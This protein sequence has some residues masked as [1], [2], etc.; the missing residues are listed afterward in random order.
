[1]K[2]YCRI[3]I[4]TI[5]QDSEMYSISRVRHVDVQCLTF[6]NVLTTKIE[7]FEIR[8][9]CSVIQRVPKFLFFIKFVFR[10]KLLRTNINYCTTVQ[11]ITS[12]LLLLYCCITALLYY[13]IYVLQSRKFKRDI[14][15]GLCICID[16]NLR[17]QKI[18]ECEE[19]T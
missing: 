13:Y 15:W 18:R 2:Q 1:M 9:A 16:S 4:S 5:L 12:L 6:I 10:P 19:T 17:N 14:V 8:R 11:P 7:S 3:Q